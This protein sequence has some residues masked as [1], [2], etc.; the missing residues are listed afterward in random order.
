M[1]TEDGQHNLYLEVQE[2]DQSKCNTFVKSVVLPQL[3]YVDEVR[4]HKADIQYRLPDWFSMLPRSVTIACD[5]QV[6]REVLSRA[7]GGKYPNNLIGWFDLRPLIDTGVYHQAVEKYHT[8][9]KPWHHA[10]T[11]VQA[12]LAG[13]LAWINQRRKKTKRGKLSFPIFLLH[14]CKC[15]H[16]FSAVKS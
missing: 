1:V 4:V 8:K 13:W 5:S 15:F 3:G 16:V 10:F 11:D 6:D 14:Y 9:E 2:F 7:F 12:H